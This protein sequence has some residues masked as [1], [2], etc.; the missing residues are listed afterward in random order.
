MRA[1]EL[2]IN[3]QERL[4]NLYS[5]ELLDTLPEKD[6]DDITRLA[7][8]ICDTPVSLISLIDKDRQWFKST[9]GVDIH[10]TLREHAFCSHAILNPNEL[11]VVPD[12]TQDERFF[13]NPLVTGDYGVMFYAGVPLLTEEGY[14]LGSLCVLDNKPKDLHESQR[15]ALKTLANQT[16][17]LMQLH[18]K[19]K[20]LTRSRQLLE[21]VNAELE[22][23]A[24]V[25]VEKLKQPCDN[26]IEFTYLMEEKFSAALD[27]DGKQM[28]S[29][30]R[31]SCES[32]KETVE[33]TLQRASRI[34]LLQ[35]SKSLFHLTQLLKELKQKLPQAGEI[36][37]GSHPANDAIYFYKNIL[38]QILAQIITASSAF[39]NSEQHRIELA[40]LPDRHQYIFH[41]ADNGKGVPVFSRNGEF[42][43]L[44]PSKE[45]HE[46]ERNYL[47]TLTS[48]RQLIL[49]LAG[50]LDMN[51]TEGS[52]TFFT[53]SVPK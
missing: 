19:A 17:R 45:A 31:Y 20:E 49:S 18:K 48:A 15:E 9:A 35:D 3:E 42:V 37:L 13:D 34:S 52:G 44:Q 39:N 5:Y 2:P 12:T 43:L 32:M 8:Y 47:D 16:M 22:T 7:S 50:S 30:I 33:N 36:M 14:A 25:V 27:V 41:I 29:L 51:F 10:E 38:L 40:F 23:F 53:I 11:M 6:Y 24:Q 21:D 26:A 28:L 4:H 46:K 1:A